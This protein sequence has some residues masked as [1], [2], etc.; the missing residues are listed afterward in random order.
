MKTTT[1]TTTT[2]IRVRNFRRLHKLRTDHR[3]RVGRPGR[4]DDHATGHAA[5]QRLFEFVPPKQ[6]LL[7]HQLRDG[8][9]CA[10]PGIGRQESAGAAKV[11]V[12]RVH[13]LRAQDLPPR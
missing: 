7:G 1:T 12:S 6:L 9:L 2:E 4:P 11:A 10:A 3:L 8:P 5:A 13:H